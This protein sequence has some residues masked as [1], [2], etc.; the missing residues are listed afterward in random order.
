MKKLLTIA[1]CF[2][3]VI[4]IK[5]NA[6]VAINNDGSSADATAMLDVK[7][8][9][10]GVK[11]PRMTTAQRN[12]IP[13]TI[14]DGGLMVFDTDDGGLYM[15]DGSQWIPFAY[16]KPNPLEQMKSKSATGASASSYLGR[17]CDMSGDYAVAGAENDSVGA[18]VG[19]GSAYVFKKVNGNWVQQARLIADD[20]AKDEKFGS[21]VA[22]DGSYIVVGAPDANAHI[23]ALYVFLRNGDTWTQQAKIV[24]VGG[25]VFSY[26]GGCVD[27]EGSTI[28][29]G[30]VS[31]DVN[32]N[33]SQG[34]AYVYTRSGTSWSLKTK[35]IANDGQ[36]ADAFGASVSIYGSYIAVGA[37]DVKVNAIKCGAAYVFVANRAGGYTQQG[38]LLSNTPTDGSYFGASISLDSNK[39]VVGS[40]Y[41]MNEGATTGSAHLFTRTI[42][43]WTHNKTFYPSTTSFDLH[44]GWNLM[45]KGDMLMICASNEAMGGNEDQGC[46]YLYKYN[47]QY[48][49]FSLVKRITDNSN[50]QSFE[51]FGESVA[52]DGL[53]YMIGAPYTSRYPQ[54][55]QGLIFFGTFQ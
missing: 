55:G 12:A 4:F 5:T 44:F 33:S 46:V 16:T 47:P 14:N 25:K 29:T 2:L 45:I 28:I 22:I 51:G 23:G 36:A 15:F 52:F 53:N 48:L 13:T 19:Q 43:T 20:G 35:V 1:V 6:Q 39:V 9:A 18:N 27:I 30:A 34:C 41:E 11:F 8:T 3:S 37:T 54:A 31:E 50:T 32:G 40:M 42:S 24:P 10:K 17:S 49:A 21:S 26:Y 7:S 38:K